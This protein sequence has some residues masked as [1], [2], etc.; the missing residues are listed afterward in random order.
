MKWNVVVQSEGVFATTLVVEA[1][2]EGEARE[3]VADFVI[4]DPGFG[5]DGAATWHKD[6]PTEDI[7]I[8]LQARVA[9]PRRR[10][11]RS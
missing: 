4:E 6:G 10:R 2:S 8:E 5:F 11:L 3:K 9:A 7:S 1:D